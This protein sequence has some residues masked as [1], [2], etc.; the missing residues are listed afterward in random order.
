MND[1]LREELSLKIAERDF[2]M[3]YLVVDVKC[4]HTDLT[5]YHGHMICGAC[6]GNG[7]VTV[8]AT[9]LQVKEALEAI[10]IYNVTTLTG[11]KNG[12]KLRDGGILRMNK[13]G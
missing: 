5:D 3:Q 6:K 10:F 2:L 8:P 13:K 4:N 1:K 11:W 9:A 7:F 12:F